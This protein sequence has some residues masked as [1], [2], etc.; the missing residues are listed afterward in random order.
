MDTVRNA[1]TMTS[2]ERRK[3]NYSVN[4]ADECEHDWEEVG[5]LIFYEKG[6]PLRGRL[7]DC[8]CD[9]RYI[10]TDKEIGVFKCKKCREVILK[11]NPW[12]KILEGE[13][14]E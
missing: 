10:K 7:S 1:E 8:E 13:K 4:P 6:A 14:D 5:S 12:R 2:S 9:E 3:D 11:W